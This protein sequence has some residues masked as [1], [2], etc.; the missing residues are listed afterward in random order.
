MYILKNRTSAEDFSGPIRGQQWIK[1]NR[2]DE[3]SKSSQAAKSREQTK[4]EAESNKM[5]Q[6][7]ST[8]ALTGTKVQSKLKLAN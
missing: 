1:L 7:I 8:T 6:N 2:S 5:G 3:R 4:H